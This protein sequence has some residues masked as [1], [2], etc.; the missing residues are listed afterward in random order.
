MPTWHD[1]IVWS[2]PHSISELTSARGARNKISNDKG[3]YA[4][5]S[6]C[7][8]PSPDRTLYLGIAVG[9]QGIRQRL[10]SYLRTS[11]TVQKADVMKHRGK[12]LISFARIRGAGGG[13]SSNTNT[14]RNDSFIHVCWA[15]V[16]LDFSLGNATGNEREWAFM[17]E[18]ALIDYYRPLY[19]T[20]DWDGYRDFDM[21]DEAFDLADIDD[22]G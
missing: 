15:S 16:P 9:K 13:G 8:P 22:E 20:A 10:R 5:V 2:V 4:F 7:H 14:P 3:F 18:R 11:V 19:N 1:Q 12:R 21:E 6:G 17:L